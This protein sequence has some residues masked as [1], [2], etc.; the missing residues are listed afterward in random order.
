MK[1]FRDLHPFDQFEIAVGI[2]STIFCLIGFSYIFVSVV[3]ADAYVV[4][5]DADNSIH[6]VAEKP[7][8]VLQP[9]QSRYVIPE[10]LPGFDNEFHYWNPQSKLIV[11]NLQKPVFPRPVLRVQANDP[12][13]SGVKGLKHAQHSFT[14]SK[15]ILDTHSPL[16]A[17]TEIWRYLSYRNFL[18]LVTHDAPPDR[19]V[20]Y[21]QRDS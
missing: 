6:T 7:N 10:Y 9:G 21:S 8:D 11:R 17:T 13:G 16:P 12:V 2:A 19:V 14:W 1:K 4:V 15:M 20:S 18:P 5:N 3:F